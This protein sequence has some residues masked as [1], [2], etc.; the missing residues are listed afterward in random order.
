MYKYS[1]E[2]LKYYPKLDH[3]YSYPPISSIT[4]DPRVTVITILWLNLEKKQDYTLS[5][6]VFHSSLR[7]LI[8]FSQCMLPLRR[9]IW[10]VLLTEKK[11]ISIILKARSINCV[12]WNENTVFFITAE[13]VNYNK[14]TYCKFAILN[15]TVLSWLMEQLLLFV[16][17]WID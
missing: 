3:Y 7:M 11:N 1:P 10:N 14:G 12:H 2:P 17:A 16:I 13:L 9:F 8:W 4:Q 5:S 6:L 15:M